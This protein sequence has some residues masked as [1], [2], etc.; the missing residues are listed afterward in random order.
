MAIVF[1]LLVL[2]SYFMQDTVDL[3]NLAVEA[4]PA[5]AGETVEDTAAPVIE[6]DGESAENTEEE[7]GN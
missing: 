4:A 2:V 1:V 6:A 5:A 3:R 7:G